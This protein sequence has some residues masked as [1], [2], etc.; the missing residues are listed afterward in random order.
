MS[1]KFPS[2]IKVVLEKTIII[3]HSKHHAAGINT[4]KYSPAGDFIAT[5]GSDDTIRIYDLSGNEIMLLEGHVEP[6]ESI[7]IHPTKKL[8][9]S[10][11]D[12]ST[13][14]LW[15][16]GLKKEIFCFTEAK[17]SINAVKFSLD[18]NTLITGGKDGI[19]RIYNLES[20]LLQQEIK[21]GIITSL[22]QHPNGELLLVGTTNPSIVVI[23]IRK[24]TKV[25]E[26]YGHRLPILSLGFSKYTSQE[27][28]YLISSSIDELVKIWDATTFDEITSFQAHSGAVHAVKFSPIN[29]SFATSSY[30]R[31]VAIWELEAESKLIAKKERYHGAKLAFTD[32]DW[33][34]DGKSLAMVS[35]DGSLRIR[36]LGESKDSVLLERNDKFITAMILSPDNSSFF[37]GLENGTLINVGLTGETL[38]ALE[39]AHTSTITDI[40]ILS[41]T[42]TIFFV[43]TSSTDKTIKI[44]NPKTFKIIAIGKNHE[45]GVRCI[46]IAPTKEYL[47][48][49][50]TDKTIRKYNL[51]P[52]LYP[53][54]NVLEN[55]Q[56]ETTT[57]NKEEELAEDLKNTI[58]EQTE[59]ANTVPL[60]IETDKQEEEQ[61]K[62]GKTRGRKRK[63]SKRTKKRT[64][65][66]K[67]TQKTHP[68][69]EEVK[70]DEKDEQDEK[71]DLLKEDLVEEN[72]NEFSFF[73]NLVEPLELEEL[74]VYTYHNQAVNTI[75]FSHNGRFF[76][77]ASNDYTIVLHDINTDIPML[78]YRGHKD[79]ILSLMFSSDDKILYSGGKDGD[80][81]IHDIESGGILRTLNVHTDAVRSIVEC[82][83]NNNFF[84][85]ISD[86]NTSALFSISGDKV[87][88]IYFATNPHAI[89]W[90]LNAFMYYVSTEIG[91]LMLVKPITDEIT[92]ILSTEENLEL[93]FTKLGNELDKI[94]KESKTNTI[95]LEQKLYWLNNRI[96]L[97]EK[98]KEKSQDPRISQLKRR[99]EDD[100]LKYPEEQRKN[101]KSIES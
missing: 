95:T 85:T 98:I 64:T 96:S 29:A 59:K 80:I 82:P 22:A 84:A 94:E 70:Q 16:L 58:S 86:D 48:T 69:I 56:L 36:I 68:D 50:S 25:L 6:I 97:L 99:L 12:D 44:W 38:N 26:I 93:V 45:G 32:L 9:A 10:G 3:S 5:G 101:V 4:V 23:D 100:L 33:S 28:E 1:E 35:A 87:G 49:T 43:I 34:P 18:G 67:K 11:S 63:S 21:I 74:Q 61:L 81:L 75:V 66:R 14:R 41:I 15:D 65:S 54:K 72:Q 77:T 39:N 71:H 31:S 55:T 89:I 88:Q 91:Q 79:H 46:A 53:T 24:G 40:K 90:D 62:K 52:I 30:D 37:L 47:L 51:K 17:K 60:S 8:L 73:D 19:I 27:K 76:A 83:I 92:Y 2:M 20:Q 7:D 57:V 78:T 42:A 13:V